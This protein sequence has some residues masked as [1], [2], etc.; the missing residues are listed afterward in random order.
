MN[1]HVKTNKLTLSASRSASSHQMCTWM[2]RDQYTLLSPW[3][4][5]AAF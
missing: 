1:R 4:L 3:T 5:G 2:G